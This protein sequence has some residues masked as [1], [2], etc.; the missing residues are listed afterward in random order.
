MADQIKAVIE[1]PDETI[2]INYSQSKKLTIVGEE[3][4]ETLLD[5][6]R[7]ASF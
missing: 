7:S 1:E 4:E 5:S 6:H 3:E 2:R